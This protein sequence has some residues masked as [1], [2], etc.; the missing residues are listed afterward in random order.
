MPAPGRSALRT[1]LL[2]LGARGRIREAVAAVVVGRGRIAPV[3]GGVVADP[4]D[5]A[6]EL[7]LLGEV[8]DELGPQH[9]REVH[10]VVALRDLLHGQLAR[11]HAEQHVALGVEDVLEVPDL[12]R[13]EVDV[14]D[15]HV[16]LLLEGEL[17]E[18]GERP[19]VAGALVFA[20]HL[21]VDVREL[22][23][24]NGRGH[25]PP[26]YS[27]PTCSVGPETIYFLTGFFVIC[28]KVFHLK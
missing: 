12:A 26:P 20:V 27:N 13:V 6:A 15:H 10:R 23:R 11:A 9:G 21:D 2:P 17:A 19:A 18:A 24:Q 8:H 14:A 1:A 16:V 7:Q 4:I 25:G 22:I 28:K 3:T 5:A